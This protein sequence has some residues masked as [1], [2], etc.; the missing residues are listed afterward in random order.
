MSWFT[1]NKL[2]TKLATAPATQPTV[3]PYLDHPAATVTSMAICQ[4]CH[5]HK[6]AKAGSVLK[7]LPATVGLLSQNLQCK[8][9]LK[10]SSSFLFLEETQQGTGGWVGYSNELWQLNCITM[11]H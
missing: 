6:K 8:L 10:S 7:A 2:A 11:F 3:E 4:L 1:A 9:E 5:Y